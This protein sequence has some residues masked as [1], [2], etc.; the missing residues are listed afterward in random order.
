MPKLTWSEPEKRLYEAGVDR[1]VLYPLS[2]AGVPWNGLVSVNEAPSGGGANPFYL[3]GVKHLNRPESEEFAATLEAFTYPPEFEECDGTL[4]LVDGL[5]AGHQRR[6]PFG[7]SYRTRIGSAADPNAGY[8]IHLI[9]NI[10]ADPTERNHQT[11]SEDPTLETFSWALTAI[12]KKFAGAKPTAHLV[13]DTT[14]A[15]PSTVM[16]LESILYGTDSSAASLPEPAD[17]IELFTS[18]L[19]TDSFIVTDNGDGTFTVT[20]SDA[21][22]GSP[23][24][25]VFTLSSDNVVDNG[26]QT[27]TA[28]SS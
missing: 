24:D 3:D 9:Y 2:T 7:L 5:F 10:T 28:T 4:E 14:K 23:I 18:G 13:V 11:L 26:D 6:K 25:G 27:Y 22:V 15:E 8:R 16:S 21:E 1:G 17:L 20:G 19:P 12:P